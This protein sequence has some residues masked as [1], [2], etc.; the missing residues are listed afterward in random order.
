MKP[1]DPT[2][3]FDQLR[4]RLHSIAYRMLG[5]VADAEDLVQDVW[6]RW[7]AADIDAIE[8]AQAWL[9]TVTS[10]LAIDRLRSTKA[11]R[12]HYVGFW[13]PEPWLD[14]PDLIA[15]THDATAPT[16]QELLEQADDISVAFLM[17][18]EKLG[19]EARVAFLL[20][21]VLDADYAQVAQALGKTEAACRQIVSRAKTQL[22]DGPVRHHV[23]PDTHYRLLAGFAQAARDGD[24]AALQA[25]MDA[26]VELTGDGG[27]VVP[28]FGKVLRGARRI[29]ALY[30]AVWLR[31][32][33]GDAVQQLALV[34]LNGSWGLLRFIDGQLESAHSM[35]TNGQQ[36]VRIDTQR[37]PLKLRRIAA[38]WAASQAVSQARGLQRL[39]D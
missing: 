13:L 4:P 27:G 18:L 22:R 23:A 20:R 21:E 33:R 11:E 30:Y 19:P 16:P 37:N 29:A 35:Q 15:S 9:V 3:L 34:R 1:P 7:H 39:R 28:S 31:S 25:L 32:Q 8:N 10:R 2:Q 26:D 6:L 38:A 36:I 12:A 14:D 17:L 5:S 24:F